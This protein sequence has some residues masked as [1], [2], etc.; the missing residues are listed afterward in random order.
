MNAQIS[1]LLVELLP[2]ATLFE[3]LLDSIFSLPVPAKGIYDISARYCEPE[4]YVEAR[5]NTFQGLVH[6]I[7]GTKNYCESPNSIPQF[8]P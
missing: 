2:I 3:T 1:P 4:V 5:Q 8:I 6:G 7:T